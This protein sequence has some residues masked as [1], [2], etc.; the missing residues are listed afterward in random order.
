MSKLVRRKGNGVL[1]ISVFEAE[2]KRPNIVIQKAR[3]I[4]SENRWAKRGDLGFEELHLYPEQL[5][6][7]PGLIK[8]ALEA[9]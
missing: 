4:R 8:E 9:Q 3:F 5:E 7:L 1:S 6:R 2:G